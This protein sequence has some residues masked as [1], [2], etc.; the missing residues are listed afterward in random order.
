[1]K[2]FISTPLSIL[3]FFA[4]FVASC[5]SEEDTRPRNNAYVSLEGEWKCDWSNHS[6]YDGMVIF[7]FQNNP[8]HVCLNQKIFLNQTK[9]N[10]MENKTARV[11]TSFFISAGFVYALQQEVLDIEPIHLQTETLQQCPLFNRRKQG[12]AE[13]YG[14]SGW[15]EFHDRLSAYERQNLLPQSIIITS[16]CSRRF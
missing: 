16:V 6:Q 3:C 13:A 15:K 2:K 7:R 8:Y 11:L 12:I 4:Y 14:Y 10:S 5:T 9:N 1:M